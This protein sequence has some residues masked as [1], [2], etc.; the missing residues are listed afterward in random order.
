MVADGEAPDVITIYEFSD[1]GRMRL[2]DLVNLGPA[3]GYW[4]L[5]RNHCTIG[6][7]WSIQTSREDSVTEQR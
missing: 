2:V 6:R 3:P 7:P 1:Q 4:S 5:L